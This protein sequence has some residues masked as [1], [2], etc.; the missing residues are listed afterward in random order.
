MNSLLKRE[1]LRILSK[2]IQLFSLTKNLNREQWNIVYKDL[3]SVITKD[4][5][6]LL[7]HAPLVQI[8]QIERSNGFCSL[9]ATSIQVIGNL[10][11]PDRSVLSHKGSVFDIDDN[12]FLYIELPFNDLMEEQKMLLCSIVEHLKISQEWR[13]SLEKGFEVQK[14]LDLLHK[15]T[16]SIRG[17]LDLSEV[18]TSTARD[19]GESLK[20]SRCFIRRYDPNI[21]GK[22]L[23]TEQ[24]YTATGLIKASD[25]IFDFET[26]WMKA[27]S[28]KAEMSINNNAENNLDSDILYIADAEKVEDPEGWLIPMA[29]AIGLKTFL[30]VPL[31]YEGMVVGSLCF[32]QAEIVRRF[33]NQEIEF[34]K[35]VADEASVAIMHAEM[36][37][38]IKQQAKTDSMTGLNNKAS[39]HELLQ[40][41][42]ERSKRSQSSLSVMMIDLD[43]LKKANDTYGHLV[44]DEMIKL[45]GTKLKQILRQVDIAARFGGDE[46]GAILPD[47]PI[48]GARQLANRLAEE[49]KATKHPIAGHLSASVGVSGSP[50][51]ELEKDLLIEEADKA[52]Y[53]AKKR[54]KGQAASADE[55]DLQGKTV[56]DLIDDLKK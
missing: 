17:T 25:T 48:S 39:F 16:V 18:L 44:G 46:F 19:L 51:N 6:L 40:N 31:I 24:E 15:I 5:S 20:V 14:R 4:I 3:W 2:I 35:Q 38:H 56:E 53:L 50:F 29:Q 36:Y 8:W 28:K 12:Y 52:L 23:A 13:L 26:D 32:H 45:L 9:L 42:I 21:P 22:V 27:L 34:I 7:N 55:E 1:P 10:E 37:K 47:T 11:I 54:G 43:F 49:I 41:E 33:E 30:G